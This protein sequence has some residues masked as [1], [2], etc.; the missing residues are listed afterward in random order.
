MKKSICIFVSRNEKPDLYINIIGYCIALFD[1]Q[2]IESIYLLK[3]IDNPLEKKLENK[4]LH[5]LKDNIILQLSSLSHGRYNSWEYAKSSFTDID[6]PK[7]ILIDVQQRANYEEF[8]SSVQI[9]CKT[10]VLLNDDV[11][12]EIEKLV[13]GKEHDFIFD[14]TGVITR[15]LIRL[16]LSLLAHKKSI[17]AFEMNKRLS[18]NEQDLIHAL[19]TTDFEYC[20]LNISR[21][22]VSSDKESSKVVS[23]VPQ[24]DKNLLINE[25]AAANT[26]QVIRV[27]LNY[28]QLKSSQT[29]IVG[30]SARYNQDKKDLHQGVI[31]RERFGLEF[32]KIN[33]ALIA[34]ISKITD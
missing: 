11:E 17:Y 7:D 8:L 32:N 23:K 15:H 34:L 16:S 31:D 6:N 20:L 9:N 19:K 25:L 26:E 33:Q 4:K 5:N 24:L 27:L 29:E 30:I 10:K 14:V 1:N 3:I 18:H 12:V 28:P 22:S 2:N 13:A 21:F